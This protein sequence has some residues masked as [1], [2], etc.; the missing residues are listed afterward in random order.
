ME[1]MT[2]NIDN[3]RRNLVDD[4]QNFNIDFHDSK[5]NWLQARQYEESMRQVEVHVVHGDGSPV[6][7]TGVN[8]VF[9]GW[10][11]EGVYR[12]IDAKHSVMIDAQN[13]IF[14]FDF[15]APAFQ[16]AGSYKQAFFRLMK[17]GMS[18]TT[19]EFSLDVMAD[20]VISGLVPSDYITPFEDLYGKL[21]D[22]ITK[23]NGDFD[24]AM[25]QW[26]KDVANLI[27]ELNSDISGINLTITEIK[28]QLSA[29]EDKIKA[30]GLLTQADFDTAV[31]DLKQ[32]I[33]DQL[34]IVNTPFRYSEK[35]DIGG[36]AK[37]D[38]LPD[39]ISKID[40]SRFNIA[41]ITD[42]HYQD[43]YLGEGEK[44]DYPYSKYSI[45]HLADFLELANHV[46]LAISLG[47]NNGGNNVEKARNYADEALYNDR[48]L[49][50]PAKGDV[51]LVPGNHD[52][53]SPMMYT[54]NIPD[55]II[56]ETELKELF[57]TTT[58]RFGEKRDGDS[59]YFYK[60]YDEHK[61]RVIT[62]WTND[63]P[64]D[65][66][67]SDGNLKYPRWLWHGFRQQQ[68]NWLANTALKVPTGYQAIIMA[69][70]PL[71][72]DKWVDDDPNVHCINHDLVAGII[73]A[74][75]TGSTYVN[76]GT[77][78]DW[79]ASVNCDFTSQ[80]AGTLIGWFDGHKHREKIDVH[81]DFK[82]VEMVN[83]FPPKL[84]DVGTEH[85]GAMTVI[86]IDTANKQVDLLGWGRATNRS[87]TY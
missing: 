58:P 31:V 44:I 50:T 67:A 29:L 60:D 1:V 80:G 4:K 53:G 72:A 79:E 59:L 18:V 35:N 75:V 81:N 26:K 43:R 20:K 22:Y 86:S 33:I 48:L 5:Y 37:S 54:R 46:D 64:E 9:E 57:A 32:Y 38:Y 10:L 68:L 3:D 13:G 28:T 19:L 74:F 16:I 39:F 17:D 56:K 62:L 40:Q 55:G 87:M 73:N 42:P 47:D 63:V 15:P 11:P 24:T 76:K 7:L 49:Y 34:S 23:S 45:N 27:T 2:F 51:A 84:T 85:E 71:S 21:Q 77:V 78:K 36:D 82:Q 8:P 25:A 61:I 52:D 83:D 30:D 66:L 6:D 65:V 69:H 12:I 41:V 70:A 14:R